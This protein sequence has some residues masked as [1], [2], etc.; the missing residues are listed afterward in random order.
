M[1][2]NS[3][4]FGLHQMPIR[5]VL[6]SACLLM[7]GSATAVEQE[8]IGQPLPAG[9]NPQ[10]LPTAPREP[11]WQTISLNGLSAGRASQILTEASL[12]DE[13]IK[14]RGLK[15]VALYKRISPSVVLVATNDGSGSGSYLG[16]N[17]IL[18]NWHVVQGA[19]EIWILFRAPKEG[20]KVDPRSMVRATI[21]KA[22]P[23]PDLA[24]LKVA[25]I[26]PYVHPIELGSAAD[27]QVGADVSAIGH[28]NGE[29]WTYTR[30]IISQIRRDAEWGDDPSHRATLIQTQTPINP[31]N[32]GGPLFSDSGKL[33]GINSYKAEGEGLNFAVSV[34]DISAF[35]KYRSKW[36][37]P[38]KTS[39]KSCS[40]RRVY[41][42]RDQANTGGLIQFDTNCDGK[43]DAVLLVPDDKSKPIQ[44]LIDKNVDGNIDIKIFDTDRD[45]KW[46]VSFHD[47]DFDGNIDFVGY[48][49]D[50]GITASSY[51]TY[52]AYVARLSL[53]GR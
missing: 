33:L 5:S 42:G 38:S 34:E 41:E 8:V 9:T 30:G 51:E 1:R 28:P 36:V 24:L 20:E 3:C 16:S 14:T 40:T 2:R 29:A 53:A 18:T 48:H 39:K 45:G 47:V 10:S 52:K 12:E 4:L 27:I 19:N 22:D 32:S 25:Y 46:D 44:A 17:L 15:E 35:L 37:L 26:P 11:D 31:G 13:P 23:V 6:V 7:A 49:P 50:G 21:T 43:A